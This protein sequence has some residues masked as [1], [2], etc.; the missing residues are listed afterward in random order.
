MT[1]LTRWLDE[2]VDL[3]GLRRALLDRPVPSGLTW[4]HTLG[5]ATLAVFLVQL[6]TGIVLATYY[7][8]SP[9]HA[10][11]SIRFIDRQVTS[12]ALLRGIHHWGASAMVVLVLA[13]MV[14]VFTW[15]AYKYPREINWTLG[16]GLLF[17]VLAF[18]FTGYL[19]P[20]DQKAYW[21]TEVGTNIAG[22]TPVVGNAVA[23]LLRGGAQLGAATLTRFFALHVLVFPTLLVGLVLLHVALVIRQGIAARPWA[24]EA[25]KD[26]IT[27]QLKDAPPRT[28][29]SGYPQFYRAAY[30]AEKTGG[31]RFWPDIIVKDVG[32]SL[33]V[34]GIIVLLALRFGAGLEAPADPTDRAYIPRP[35]WYFLPFFQ[36]LKLVPGTWE[37]AIATGVPLLLVIVLLALPFVDRRSARSLQR[38]PVARLA[39]V[40]LLAVSS[41]LFGAAVQDAPKKAPEVGRVLS[42][43]ERAGRALFLRQQCNTCHA[44]AGLG[45]GRVEEDAPDLTE[46]GLKHSP[47]W[48]HSFIEDPSRFHL[49]S[50]MPTYG[51]PTLTHQEIEEIAQYLTSLRG[52]PA[53]VVP[54]K[55]P[56]YHD[57]FPAVASP[58]EKP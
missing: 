55:Q 58:K 37:S 3:T 57:T 28:S 12:G 22:V 24:L 18:G 42:S 40:G 27:G 48:L 31:V 23:R 38:R 35:E 6:V 15:G 5:S 51:P 49:T 44:V 29:E 36:L 2:R 41:M 10:Y 9:D 16:V 20:W 1:R 54:P 46:I 25:T 30:A 19:L 11:D 33:A 17:L 34:I 21:A 43:Q 14:R 45:G 26:P 32:V 7:A 53:A 52:V 47:A 50:K 56:E 13:H 4:W 8:P 39:L